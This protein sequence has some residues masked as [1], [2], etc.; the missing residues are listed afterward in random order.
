MSRIIQ[1]L[2]AKDER[3][4]E[5]LQ[6]AVPVGGRDKVELEP[7]VKDEEAP[8]AKSDS[9]ALEGA[10]TRR[11]RPRNGFTPLTESEK[12]VK[13]RMLVKRS[14]Y[15]KIVRSCVGGVKPRLNGDS[16]W[17]IVRVCEGHAGGASEGDGDAGDRVQ[18]G[19]YLAATDAGALPAW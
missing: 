10:K 2:A 6:A 13:Q 9:S 3:P 16:D 7:V 14:Y 4:P 15:R 5:G 11:R 1:E 8:A 19:Y 18:G 17:A 12:R